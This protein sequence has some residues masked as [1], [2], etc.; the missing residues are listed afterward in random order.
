MKA[1]ITAGGRATRLRPITFTINKHLIP[2]VN[3]PMLEYALEKI[4]ECGITEVAININPGETELQKI[5]GDGSRWGMDITYLEQ[6]G[7]PKGLAHIISNAAEWL[8]D[9]PFLF[10]LGD[11]IIL[12]SIKSLVEKFQR[13]EL[14]CLLALSRV[15]DPQRFGVPELRNGRITRVLEK[16]SDPPSDFA[17]TGIYIYKSSI[18][19]ACSDIQPSARG[20][21]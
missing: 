15:P 9:E 2:L 3:K 14:D 7:G 4:Q 17:V 19:R 11:N 8:G 1:L 20:E 18:L 10:Y 13:E 5:L 6:Q 12:G 21:Y 16:P